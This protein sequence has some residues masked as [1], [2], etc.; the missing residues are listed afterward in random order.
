VEP[1]GHQTEVSILVEGD[2]SLSLHCEECDEQ[3][4]EEIF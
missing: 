4:I 3:R 2:V 1:A